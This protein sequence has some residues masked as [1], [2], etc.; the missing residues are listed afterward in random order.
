MHAFVTIVELLPAQP[1]LHQ[2]V[3]AQRAS[4]QSR[5]ISA[6]ASGRFE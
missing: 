5:T 2:L 1:G 4:M 3:V 6:E